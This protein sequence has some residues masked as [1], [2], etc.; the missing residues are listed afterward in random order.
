MNRF[1]VDELYAL[2]QQLDQLASLEQTIEQSCDASYL[3][4]QRVILPVY[5]DQAQDN[6]VS[7]VLTALPDAAEKVPS[8]SRKDAMRE[9]ESSVLE[10]LESRTLRKTRENVETS[11]RLQVFI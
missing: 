10:Q 6:R 5:L 11:L 7:L 2:I 4:H 1:Q 9:F 3:Y 8:S